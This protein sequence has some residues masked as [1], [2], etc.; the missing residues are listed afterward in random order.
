M[1]ESDLD[2]ITVEFF[3]MPITMGGPPN[4][5]LVRIWTPR[6]NES[7]NVLEVGVDIRSN[8]QNE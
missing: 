5:L 7:R 6:F 1:P 8:S 4:P 3:V 2:Q